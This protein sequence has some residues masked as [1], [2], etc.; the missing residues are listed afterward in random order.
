[1]QGALE[2]VAGVEDVEMNWDDQTFTVTCSPNVDPDDLKESVEAA[3]FGAT[4]Q[5]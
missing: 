2:G 3:N 4:I 5:K 1:M